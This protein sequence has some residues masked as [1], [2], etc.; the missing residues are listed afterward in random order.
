[1][2][3]I[4]LLSFISKNHNPVKVV[5]KIDK[6]SFGNI[7]DNMEDEQRILTK[8][9]VCNLKALCDKGMKAHAHM[10]SQ[11]YMARED[12]DGDG[13]IYGIDWIYE[14]PPPV[15]KHIKNENIEKHKFENIR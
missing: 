7:I 10:C 8:L 9:F 12:L 6:T 4:D 11:E 2:S 3:F 1:M 13:L 15:L 14:N 5:E